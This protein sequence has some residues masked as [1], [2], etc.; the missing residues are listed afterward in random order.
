M[1][2]TK[3]ADLIAAYDLNL[4]RGYLVGYRLSAV[5]EVTKRLGKGSEKFSVD[6][7]T[8]D[9]GVCDVLTD[10]C[11]AI[12]RLDLSYKHYCLFFPGLFQIDLFGEDEW[13]RHYT[14]QYH[15]LCEHYGEKIKLDN[16]SVLA[17]N[18]Y[19]PFTVIEGTDGH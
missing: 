19:S 13:G 16:G 9:G 12:L 5:N 17:G 1:E 18:D 2:K 4:K 15:R 7:E 14:A 11:N 6:T 8:V 10:V 3:E